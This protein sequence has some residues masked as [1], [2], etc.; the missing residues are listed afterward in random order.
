MKYQDRSNA[1]ALMVLSLAAAT[2]CATFGGPRSPARPSDPN[3][4]VILTSLQQARA[5]RNLRPP[6][7]VQ[8][9]EPLAREGA[10]Q[11]AGGALGASVLHQIGSKAANGFGHNVS[12]WWFVA[13]DLH[14]LEW[15][16]QLLSGRSLLVSVGVALMRT[17]APGRYAVIIIL[18]EPGFG[19]Q[20]SAAPRARGTS[21]VQR[22]ARERGLQHQDARIDSIV[23]QR[24]VGQIQLRALEHQ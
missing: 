3:E 8:R 1:V 5:Q 13:D 4:D 22:P 6:T 21:S 14:N 12:T 20:A 19:I 15:P 11:L 2:G 9:L 24:C 10:E 16:S 7:W 18:P 23:E 17:T